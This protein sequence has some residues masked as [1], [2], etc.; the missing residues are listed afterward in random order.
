MR[1][2]FSLQ[3]TVA[4]AG[5]FYIMSLKVLKID[6]YSMIPVIIE[7]A[8]R[9]ITDE[10]WKLMDEKHVWRLSGESSE[11]YSMRIIFELYGSAPAITYEYNPEVFRNVSVKSIHDNFENI[12]KVILGKDAKPEDVYAEIEQGQNINDKRRKQIINQLLRKC[13][14]F[15]SFDEMLLQQVANGCRL[16]TL[17]E[18][19]IVI[20][21]GMEVNSLYFV[22]EGAVSMEGTRRDAYSVP[23]LL[24]KKGDVF[25][26]EA[27]TT[28]HISSNGYK[29][30][31]NNTN[32][33][34][35]PLLALANVI[36]E[37][38]E[39]IGELFEIMNKR[40]MKFER[41][42]MME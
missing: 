19:D 13:S 9:L 22:V 5:G 29:A 33:V 3:K 39:I 25:G 38:Y 15:S 30:V 20:E 2:P 36:N 40:L 34:E 11:T 42:W 24:L 37:H 12:L 16:M 32:V 7:F 10:Q 4:L 35:I 6:F 8:E 17:A 27:F 1:G 26:I 23:L 14:L 41:L 21:N 28:S 31:K 18:E